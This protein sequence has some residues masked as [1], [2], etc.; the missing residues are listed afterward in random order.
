MQHCTTEHSTYCVKLKACVLCVFVELQDAVEEV[1][2]SL[3]EQ[4]ISVYLLSE[5]CKIQGINTLSDKISQASDQPLSPQ[6]RANIH[7]RSTA[8][9][10]YTSG[11]TGTPGDVSRTTLI[12]EKKKCHLKAV[13]I[14]LS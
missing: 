6:L 4:D 10:I 11:T 1:L 3:R 12:N 2:P 9:Y 13:E 7:I 8:L 5:T 14:T